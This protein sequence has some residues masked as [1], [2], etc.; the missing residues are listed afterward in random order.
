V[1]S[2]AAQIAALEKSKRERGARWR[3][4]KVAF[5]SSIFEMHREIQR[6][7]QEIKILDGI[8]AAEEATEAWKTSWR[9]WLLSPLYKKTKESEEEKA[10]KDRGRQERRIEKDMKERRLRPKKANLEKEEIL[11][12]MAKEEVETADQEDDK[13]IKLIQERI[14]ARETLERQEKER[15]YR[16]KVQEQAEKEAESRRRQQAQQQ[17]EKEAEA[18]RRQPAAAARQQE[19]EQ[20]RGRSSCSHDGWWQRVQGRTVCPQCQSMWT[21]LLQCPGCELQVCPKCQ[22]AIRRGR[23][24]R[25][26]Q[27]IRTPNPDS[28]DW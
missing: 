16:Q 24:R 9:A 22:G 19:K 17:A 6:L 1:D 3:T 13:K 23:Q 25:P 5:D 18:R 2:E 4:R 10:L 12:R 8:A 14:R 11:L 21:Y 7:E 27:R 28:Y 15:Q 20:T 26:A